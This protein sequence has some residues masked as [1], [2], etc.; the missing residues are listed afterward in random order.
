M[1]E[2]SGRRALI[3][4]GRRTKEAKQYYCDMPLAVDAKTCLAYL[5]TS[6]LVQVQ[7]PQNR[8]VVLQSP[9]DSVQK[10]RPFLFLGHRKCKFGI[11]DIWRHEYLSEQY[12][13]GLSQ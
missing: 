11:D 9:L 6:R 5:P 13:Y 12:L 3:D 7:L 2:T 1:E 8:P 4:V 10:S